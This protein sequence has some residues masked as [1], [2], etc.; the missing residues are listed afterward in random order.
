M[1]ATYTSRDIENGVELGLC[2]SITL[3]RAI[4][5]F[6]TMLS[7]TKVSDIKLSYKIEIK[8]EKKTVKAG[9]F[10]YKINGSLIK[11]K[12]EVLKINEDLFPYLD[13]PFKI[14]VKEFMHFLPTHSHPKKDLD[15]SCR[16]ELC[17]WW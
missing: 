6:T 4:S 17:V 9:E 8:T 10:S 12:M 14:I 3:F 7:N 1:I 5:P 16:C 15:D 11:P 2:G 13:Q